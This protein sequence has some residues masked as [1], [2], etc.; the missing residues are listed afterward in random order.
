MVIQIWITRI[1]DKVVKVVFSYRHQ[2]VTIHGNVISHVNMK[3]SARMQSM[4]NIDN[5]KSCDGRIKK[6]DI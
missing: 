6:R 1:T 2:M 5:K 3:T 4:D